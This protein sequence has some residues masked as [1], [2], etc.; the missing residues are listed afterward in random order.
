MRHETRNRLDALEAKEAKNE[1]AAP[2][3]VVV[4]GFGETESDALRRRGIEPAQA[5]VLV[6]V[7]DMSVPR[8]EA[9]P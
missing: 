1:P 6:T 7:A 9:M 8:P 4:V 3:P 2:V 5:F